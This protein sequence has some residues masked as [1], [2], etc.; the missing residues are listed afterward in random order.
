[1]WTDGSRFKIG[2]TGDAVLDKSYFNYL[3]EL[4]FK[5]FKKEP[6]KFTVHDGGL[7]FILQSKE[8]FNVFLDL[9]MKGGKKARTVV[10]PQKIVDMGWNYSKYTVRGIFDTDGTVFFSKKTYSNPIYPTVEICTYS[11]N[12]ANQ[13]AELL[14]M[15]GFRARKR[16]SQNRGFYVALYGNKMLEKWINEIGSSNERHINRLT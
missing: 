12:L 16:G 8:A 9:G 6:Y 5:L 13:L 10:I 7:R 3:R 15:H 14:K 4:S 1:M 11:N 2:I